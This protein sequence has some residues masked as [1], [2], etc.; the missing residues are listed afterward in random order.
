MY[1]CAKKG[2]KSLTKHCVKRGKILNKAQVFQFIPL[3]KKKKTQELVKPV[4]SSRNTVDYFVVSLNIKRKLQN[5]AKETKKLIKIFQEKV[6]PN[7][8]HVLTAKLQ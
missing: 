5:V 6:T 7:D 1:N 8:Q 2:L 3:Q 4:K